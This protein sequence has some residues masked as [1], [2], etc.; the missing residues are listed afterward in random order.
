[1]A[2][3]DYGLPWETWPQM[4]HAMVPTVLSVALGSALAH[5]GD[6]TLA[7]TSKNVGGKWAGSRENARTKKLTVQ[8]S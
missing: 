4:S 6:C 3:R 8:V 5:G 2:R 1:M 7:R